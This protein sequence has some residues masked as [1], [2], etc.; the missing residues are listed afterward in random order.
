MLDRWDLAATNLKTAL[1]IDK[2][3]G[4]AKSA[5]K[6]AKEGQEAAKH[7]KSSKAKGRNGIDSQNSFTGLIPNRLPEIQRES[8]PPPCAD[9]PNRVFY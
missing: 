7:G 8:T 2:N 1:K 6:W 9:L 5:L 3:Y 4:D